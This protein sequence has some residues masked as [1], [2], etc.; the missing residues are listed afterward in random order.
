MEIIKY[1]NHQLLIQSSFLNFHFTNF[2]Q[3]SH[4]LHNNLTISLILWSNLAN[5]NKIFTNEKVVGKPVFK[6]FGIIE[7]II[8]AL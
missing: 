7:I 3:T 1:Q 5:Y 6:G 2:T 8:Y 4:K